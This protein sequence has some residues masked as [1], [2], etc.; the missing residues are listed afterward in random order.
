M[1]NQMDSE[2]VSHLKNTAERLMCAMLDEFDRKDIPFD[3]TYTAVCNLFLRIMSTLPDEC[4]EHVI[5]ELPIMLRKYRDEFKS[6]I[7]H[8]E[9]NL[10]E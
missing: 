4:I 5:Q 1:A 7:K 3:V 10:S 2:E 6:H 8:L 9:E